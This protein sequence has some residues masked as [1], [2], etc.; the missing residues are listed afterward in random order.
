MIIIQIM[1]LE[2]R[3]NARSLYLWFKSEWCPQSTFPARPTA[4]K[5]FIAWSDCVY[6]TEQW[7]PLTHALG[8]GCSRVA[9]CVT[10]RW[11]NFSHYCPPPRQYDVWVTCSEHRGALIAA[12]AAHG[13]HKQ[14]LTVQGWSTQFATKQV[15][16]VRYVTAVDGGLKRFSLCSVISAPVH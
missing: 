4:S 11:R 14:A 6:V 5:P 13:V 2:H 7:R 1:H 15:G 12:P 3:K 8:H 9:H 16:R 10:A